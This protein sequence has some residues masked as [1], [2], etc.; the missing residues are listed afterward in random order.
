MTIAVKCKSTSLYIENCV[1]PNLCVRACVVWVW[2]SRH[3]ICNFDC[4]SVSKIKQ[5]SDNVLLT[6]HNQNRSRCLL[7]NPGIKLCRVS[8]LKHDPWLVYTIPLYCDV[9]HEI[10]PRR[11]VNGVYWYIPG[12]CYPLRRLLFMSRPEQDDN[13]YRLRRL[14]LVI[15]YIEYTMNR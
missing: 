3:R 10:R 6:I 14:S 12:Y 9:D 11:L 15:N 1:S 4:S 13:S 7:S 2:R 8:F 5:K